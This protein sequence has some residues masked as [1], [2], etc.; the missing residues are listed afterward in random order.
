MQTITKSSTFVQTLA[1]VFIT[2]VMSAILFNRYLGFDAFRITIVVFFVFLA[3]KKFKFSKPPKDILI[4]YLSMVV[5]FVYIAISTELSPFTD[6]LDLNPFDNWILFLPI[7]YLVSLINVTKEKLFFILLTALIFSLFPA[8]HDLY[9]GLKRYDGWHGQPIMWGNLSILTGILL[10]ILSLYLKTYFKLIGFISLI[11]GCAICG[12]SQTRGGWIA[13]IAIMPILSVF[14]WK[15]LSKKLVLAM[16]IIGFFGITF[17]LTSDHFGLRDRFNLIHDSYQ[18][19]Q[20]GHSGTSLGARIDLWQSSIRA[21]KERPILGVSPSGFRPWLKIDQPLSK[22]WHWRSYGHSHNEYLTWLS[23]FG[24]IGSFIFLFILISMWKSLLHGKVKRKVF[25]LNSHP[26]IPLSVTLF[27]AYISFCIT[28]SFWTSRLGSAYFMTLFCLLYCLK[29]SNDESLKNGDSHHLF[30]VKNF[31]VLFTPL[32][33]IY[34]LLLVNDSFSKKGKGEDSRTLAISNIHKK[35]NVKNIII[36]KELGIDL[37]QLKGSTTNYEI[38]SIKDMGC[39]IYHPNTYL[40]IPSNLATKKGSGI[41]KKNS[42]TIK[43]NQSMIKRAGYKNTIFNVGSD[44][45]YEIGTTVINPGISFVRAS[46]AEPCRPPADGIIRIED[47]LFSKPLSITNQERLNLYSNVTVT[48]P[49]YEFSPGAHWFNMDIRGTTAK[50]EY[51]KIQVKVLNVNTNDTLI[52]KIYVSTDDYKSIST[53]L[54][55]KHKGDY[56]I[57]FSFINDY[58]DKETDED[59]NAYAKNIK[60]IGTTVFRDKKAGSM[61]IF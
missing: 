56:S 41:H 50:N 10:F 45:P 24:L 20:Q 17:V 1:L 44:T 30:N 52:E 3:I 53:L 61:N 59:R 29:A 25:D 51:A 31:L 43:I 34:F 14:M 2:F 60:I 37:P 49:A 4:I 46:I 38:E 12:V 47:L 48:L 35:Y 36:A 54:E 7:F 23:C 19:Y 33:L 57:S 15:S 8:I 22:K 16:F 28:E 32:V 39:R 13:L 55:V 5:F 9:T 58:L 42:G 18:S 6:G 40:L 27:V 26:A 21:F 11:V